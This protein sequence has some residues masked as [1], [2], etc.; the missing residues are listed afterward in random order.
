ML[1]VRARS[2]RRQV[3]PYQSSPPQAEKELPCAVFGWGPLLGLSAKA[4]DKSQAKI[5]KGNPQ[6]HLC[7]ANVRE[8]RR[9]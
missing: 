2:A 7:E 9:E 3:A 6:H 8:G 1:W 4:M 5:W